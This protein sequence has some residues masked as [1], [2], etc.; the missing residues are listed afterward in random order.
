MQNVQAGG[1]IYTQVFVYYFEKEQKEIQILVNIR[2]LPEPTTAL[3]G[4]KT[5]LA[6]LTE[7]FTNP[8]KRL[9]IIVAAGG[10]G[11]SALTDE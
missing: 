1:D 4:R 10:I 11:K 8:N 3:I 7:A 5:E 2:H 6:Q 9:A